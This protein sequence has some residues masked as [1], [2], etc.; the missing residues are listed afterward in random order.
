MAIRMMTDKDAQC[1]QCSI[2]CLTYYYTLPNGVGVGVGVMLS[3]VG[4]GVVSSIGVTGGG[5]LD[6]AGVKTRTGFEKI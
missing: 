3:R 2:I 5:G 4:V 1:S 6:V